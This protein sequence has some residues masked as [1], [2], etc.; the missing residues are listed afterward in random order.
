[1]RADV[2]DVP[3]VGLAEMHMS[4]DVAEVGTQSIGMLMWADFTSA[5]RALPTPVCGGGEADGGWVRPKRGRGSYTQSG[6]G[7]V[8]RQQRNLN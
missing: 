4:L 5:V 6:G 7:G 1:M 2:E 8:V 3:D